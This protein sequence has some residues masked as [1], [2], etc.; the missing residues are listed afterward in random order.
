[1]TTPLDQMKKEAREAAIEHYGL[2]TRQEV[3][4]SYN[5]IDSLLTKAF[6]AGETEGYKK[7]VEHGENN[8]KFD[9]VLEQARNH[10]TP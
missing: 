9:I 6:E 7:G 3:G 5:F 10:K 8:V 2:R 4:K 1:M